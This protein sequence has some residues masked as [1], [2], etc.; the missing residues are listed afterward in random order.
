MLALINVPHEYSHSRD[1]FFYKPR[2]AYL[3][4]LLLSMTI[5][6]I[7]FAITLKILLHL[8]TLCLPSKLR[9]KADE[10]LCFVSR[11]L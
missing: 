2:K 6:M 4:K 9:V 3:A 11:V 7:G 8:E 5:G 10:N 1:P